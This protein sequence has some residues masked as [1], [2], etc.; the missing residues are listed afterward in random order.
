MQIERSPPLGRLTYLR[1]FSFMFCLAL[2]DLL[3]VFYSYSVTRAKGPSV[4]LLFGFEVSFYFSS[5]LYSIY[6]CL[7]LQYS[8]CRTFRIVLAIYD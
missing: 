6:Y 8:V 1:V 7:Y 2:F 5:L 4:M 3:F